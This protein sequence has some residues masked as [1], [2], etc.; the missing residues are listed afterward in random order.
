MEP[1]IK[2]EN[3]A[4]TGGE[5]SQAA[6]PRDA[7]CIYVIDGPE[8][9]DKLIQSEA[10]DQ[11]PRK[12]RRNEQVDS[13]PVPKGAKSTTTKKV[14]L[15]DYL[16]KPAPSNVKLIDLRKYCMMSIIE[17]NRSAAN[18]FDKMAEVLPEFKRF[19]ADAPKLKPMQ[20]KQGAE[21]DHG[22]SFRD[23]NED[24]DVDT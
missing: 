17:H 18:F 15:P 11:Q 8:A 20:N 9:L 10:Q 2:M 21:A 1:V 23:A 14:S 16:T 4:A 6:L 22:Y 3:S 7:T 12:R 13:V 24:S 5:T 19:I